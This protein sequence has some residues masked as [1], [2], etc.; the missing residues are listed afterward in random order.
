MFTYVGND[1]YDENI[2]NYPGQCDREIS[3]TFVKDN[4]TAIDYE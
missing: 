4:A 2:K 1:M 3:E